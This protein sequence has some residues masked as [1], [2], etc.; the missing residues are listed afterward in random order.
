[1]EDSH[2]ITISGKLFKKGKI[3]KA[4]KTRY[5]M[6]SR[7]SQT[8]RYYENGTDL[9]E[10]KKE[11]GQI[12]LTAICKIELNTSATL[13][14]KFLK[15]V[16]FNDELTSDKPYTFHLVSAHRTYVLAAQNKAQLIEWLN[17]LYLCLYSG[18]VIKSGFL[19]K[20]MKSGM[21]T[22]FKSRYYVLNSLQHL[23]SYD[24]LN[25]TNCV[26]SI[27]CNKITQIHQNKA[28]TDTTSTR[29]LFDIHIDSRKW[30]LAAHSEQQRSE[31]IQRI[32]AMRSDK[33]RDAH[34]TNK[35]LKINKRPKDDSGFLERPEM[36]IEDQKEESDDEPLKIN[37]RPMHDDSGFFER[38]NITKE[39]DTKEDIYCTKNEAIINK[40]FERERLDTYC[41][42][43]DDDEK[44]SDADS[45]EFGG[46]WA[47]NRVAIVMA[48]SKH[49][50]QN[51][52][53]TFFGESEE[54]IYSLIALVN[55]YQHIMCKHEAE[56]E[57]ITQFLITQYGLECE[58]LAKCEYVSRNYRN[59]SRFFGEKEKEMYKSIDYKM[60][61]IRKQLDKM[62]SCLLHSFDL[63]YR[64]TKGEKAQISD[65]KYDEGEDFDIDD[66]TNQ[67]QSIQ[68]MQ[69]VMESKQYKLREL[70]GDER[71]LNTKFVTNVEVVDQKDDGKED[72]GPSAAEYSFGF[73]FKYYPRF[74]DNKWFVVRVYDDLKQEILNNP[75]HALSLEQF[76][77]QLDSAN[78]YV[79]CVHLKALKCKHIDIYDTEPQPKDTGLAT[80]APITAQHILVLLF[81]CNFTELCT[82]FSCTFRRIRKNETDEEVKVR[83]GYFF[84][85]SR[86]LLETLHLFGT[87]LDKREF[88]KCVFHGVNRAMVFATMNQRVFCPF[89]TTSQISVALQFANRGLVLTLQRSSDLGNQKYFDCSYISDFT[90]ESE[91]L[92]FGGLLQIDDILHIKTKHSYRWYCRALNVLTSMLSATPLTAPIAKKRQKEWYLTMM[93]KGKEY[94]KHPEYLQSLWTHVVD[95]VSEITIDL[96]LL[97]V[98]IVYSKDDRDAFTMFRGLRQQVKDPTRFGFPMMK[99]FLL[100][101]TDHE[102]V[103]LQRLCELFPNLECIEI[104]RYKRG[105]ADANDI[106]IN[107]I[108][109][110]QSLIDNL[111]NYHPPKQLVVSFNQP[112]ETELSIASFI[113]QCRESQKGKI[114]KQFVC[115]AGMDE[116]TVRKSK[117]VW[118]CFNDT[119]LHQ[120]CIHGEEDIVSRILAGDENTIK[121]W[122]NRQARYTKMTPLMA[123]CQQGHVRC[124]E[125]LL[126]SDSIDISINMNTVDRRKRNALINSVRLGFHGIVTTLLKYS[127]LSPQININA[128]DEEGNSALY[129]AVKN[130]DY[131]VFTAIIERNPNADLK[132][133]YGF[134]ALHHACRNEYN[135]LIEELLRYGADPNSAAFT[136]Q[137]CL[138]S[139]VRKKNTQA[140]EL[141]IKYGANLN[142]TYDAATSGLFGDRGMRS[143]SAMHLAIDEKNHSAILLLLNG[144]VD[145]TIID[146]EGKTFLHY[147][148]D[149]EQVEILKAVY[150]SVSKQMNTDELYDFINHQDNRGR[151]A[152][153]LSCKRRSRC[154]CL[155]F[156]LE[157]SLCDL[158]LADEEGKSPLASAIYYSSLYHTLEIVQ[159]LLEAGASVHPIHVDEEG[160]SLLFDCDNKQIMEALYEHYLQHHGSE[161]ALLFVNHQDNKGQTALFPASR[162][163]EIDCAEY[164][165]DVGVKIQALDHNRRSVFH[166]AASSYGNIDLI[167]MMY[168]KLKADEEFFTWKEDDDDSKEDA[169]TKF[170]NQSDNEHVTALFEATANTKKAQYLL[171]VGGK[172]DPL[173]DVNKILGL[174]NETALLNALGQTSVCVEIVNILLDAGAKPDE[175]DDCNESAL[176]KAV[177]RIDKEKFDIL[178]RIYNKFL[179]DTDII[180]ATALVNH[181]DSGGQTAL[182]NVVHDSILTGGA[183]E[184][185]IIV[186]CVDFLLSVGAAVN[187]LDDEGE[188]P[189]FIAAKYGQHEALKSMY[190]QYLQD[191]DLKSATRLVNR[192][193][194]IKETPLFAA[195]TSRKANRK[196]VDFL[197]NAGARI[198]V[199]DEEG[200]S[201]FHKAVERAEIAIIQTVFKRYKRDTNKDK[202]IKL[203]NH[204]N[205][206]G[207]TALMLAASFGRDLVIEFLNNNCD[208]KLN[209]TDTV[210]G[211]TALHYAAKKDDTVDGEW[212]KTTT[213]EFVL[214]L[215]MIDFDWVGNLTETAEV[216]VNKQDFDGQTALHI[217]CIENCENAVK[218]L[219]KNEMCDVNIKNNNNETAVMVAAK[220]GRTKIVQVLLHAQCILVDGDECEALRLARTKNQECAQVIE[221]YLRQTLSMDEANKFFEKYPEQYP[222]DDDDDGGCVIM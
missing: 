103:H 138:M 203:I 63:N 205:N 167:K 116:K 84:H 68:T 106:L 158:N 146:N 159:M 80:N 220:K 162:L 57:D 58:H 126:C 10:S 176:H 22:T 137:T 211:R 20:K 218:Y 89:S 129:Y 72:K 212:T 23:K 156:L 54:A 136:G 36:P 37:K 108:R 30:S 28:S 60:M 157:T 208:A 121:G 101:D 128:C 153:L 123:A 195:T 169:L 77:Q 94:D 111:S 134:S 192:T 196:C 25:L 120:A 198:N 174:S 182:R 119:A 52:F 213:V 175:F 81:Y 207:E 110:T 61:S 186:E 114:E 44:I 48:S 71:M 67:N 178:K 112:N 96:H 82:K 122:I 16:V 32:D 33:C 13:D 201:L 204:Q 140:T 8:I 29:Y 104:C 100:L 47:V 154:P 166:H 62:H 163:K 91:K 206:K 59:R 160:K 125:L 132:N 115:Q 141:L 26:E 214:G 124:V 177:H 42:Q 217:A 221:G 83:N 90:A 15:H 145:A 1:M 87:S 210:K 148:V 173:C 69:K 92:F 222:D 95:C 109:L 51:T 98:N 105:N 75:V 117:R 130:N 64:F 5:F 113:A 79:Q 131:T 190:N 3:N 34:D 99:E 102:W 187:I 139:T 200:N 151:T 199:F 143:V 35:P 2:D 209:V 118:I 21:Q 152:L 43:C 215:Y 24:N 147:A 53:E 179:S 161:S 164:L 18:K 14:A 17:F 4:W 66:E 6:G 183:A 65:T 85:F 27:D 188:S 12:D 46:C 49:N 86:F 76:E 185:D 31:W 155:R 135:R 180:T 149:E 216:F 197:L 170:I 168:Q 184:K 39:D 107:G 45:C 133:V 74:K 19:E 165:I 142:L 70:V 189:I 172:I 55:D 56:L 194:N 41:D 202:A 9:N 38:P 150:A 144:G 181:K 88:G 97:K 219:V 11:K 191:T 78:V 127:A 7:L 193:N 171:S 73:P 50:I 40:W 93:R